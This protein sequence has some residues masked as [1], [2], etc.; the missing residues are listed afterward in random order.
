M[1]TVQEYLNEAEGHPM[2]SLNDDRVRIGRQKVLWIMKQYGMDLLTEYTNYL[3]K[4]GYCDEDVLGYAQNEPS[5]IDKFLILDPA[6]KT[7]KK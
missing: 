7:I 1:K 6:K 2:Y 3:L 4:H 5:A